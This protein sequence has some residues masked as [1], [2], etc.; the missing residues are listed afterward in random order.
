MKIID[1]VIVNIYVIHYFI[2]ERN[3]FKPVLIEGFVFIKKAIG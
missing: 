1:N 3:V 2:K